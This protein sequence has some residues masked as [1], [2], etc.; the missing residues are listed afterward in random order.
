MKQVFL[1]GKGQ[2]EVFDVPTPGRPRGC[3]LVANACSLISTGT[4]VSSVT[5]HQGLLGL[6]EKVKASKDKLYTLQEF[7]R[8]HG[9]KKTLETVNNK[10]IDFN[11]IG[12]SSA[13][14]IIEV[15]EGSE[16][17]VGDYVSCMGVG[18]A[19]H[20]QYITVPTN[21]MAKI[22]RG[23]S[24]EEASFGALACIALQGIRR[25]D[26]TPGETVTVIGLG[27]IGQLTVRFLSA[28]GYIVYGV[29]LDESR[30]DIANTVVGVAAWSSAQVN[31]IES[32]SH[33]TQ[34]HG[35]DGVIICAASKESSIINLACDLCRQRGRVSIVGDIGLELQRAKLYKK[36]IEVRMSCSY[37]PGRYDPDYEIFGNDYPFS[38]VRWTENRNLSYFL[39]LLSTKKVD[40]SKLITRKTHISEATEAYALLKSNGRKE[41]SVIL[42]YALDIGVAS[43]PPRLTTTIRLPRKNITNAKVKLG[44]IGVGAYF[45]AMHLPNLRKLSDQ[46]EISGIASRSGGTAAVVAKR[47]KVPCI[48]SD[49]K[50][51]LN[52]P[53]IDAV[54]ISTR[55]S[56]HGK[57]AIAALE[58]GKH[59]FVE[60]PMTI[61]MDEARKIYMLAQ[62][63]G[64]I[65]RVGFNRRFSPMLQNMKRALNTD[66]EKLLTCRINVGDV[67][68]HWSNT[69]TEGGRLIGEGVHFFDLCNWFMD[70]YPISVSVQ[71]IGKKE[72]YNPNKVIT[73]CYGD[74]SVAQV[75]YHTIGH[76]SMGKEYFEAVAGNK[77]VVVNDYKT[78]QGFGC[79]VETNKSMISDKGQLGVLCEFSQAIKGEKNNGAD[80]AAGLFATWVALQANTETEN[81]IDYEELGI[82]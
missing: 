73:M 38:Y 22:P 19:N 63:R 53:E 6:Y 37:G 52:D 12:Y 36:E 20:A 7:Y 75:I 23:V 34:G 80:A 82:V 62:E 46:F 40:I 2:V 78:A 24:F 13:G 60:K 74:G 5:K 81:V 39:S 28:M 14:I 77:S 30:V 68:S 71:T 27:L 47:L 42:D 76:P 25:L 66:S 26:L 8:L 15:D 1:S 9:L 32:I 17:Q 57:I 69:A 16:F 56:T 49:Y 55:H 59:I 3:A 31:V 61:C 35:S 33:H 79:K 51:L 72:P 43:E 50:E 48:T 54:L 4:E 41:F 64:L 58:A 21:L 44:L 18:F 10:L 67:G 70:A 45:K 29:D 11:P 65:V